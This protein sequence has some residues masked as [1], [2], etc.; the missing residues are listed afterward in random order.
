MDK[1]VIFHRFKSFAVNEC[2]GSSNLYE[3]LSERTAE[4]EGLLELCTNSQGGQPI[5]N[6]FFGAVHFLLLKGTSHHLKNFYG[7]ITDTPENPNQCFPYLKDF[8]KK[9]SDE[10]ITVMQRKLV[11][12]NEVRRCS[13]LYPSFCFAYEKVQ[14]PLALIEIGTSAGLQLLW[15]KYSYTYK[16]D[17]VYGNND[18]IVQ[19]NGEVEGRGFPLLRKNSP[20]VASRTGIDLHVSDLNDPDDFLW[21]KAL[22]WPEHNDRRELFERAANYATRNHLNLIEGDGVA[23][24]PEIIKEIPK[25]SAIIV[26][27]THVA[28]QF[29]N[30][31]KLMLLEEI[32]N[33]GKERDTFHLY[34]NMWDGELHLDY[35]LDGNE[36]NFIVGETDSHGRWFT[37]N[38]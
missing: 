13:Y 6:L 29:S 24:L 15:D 33:M 35:Y 10:I 34:N 36:H 32:R 3:I 19:I 28:N 18:S 25:D 23:L 8:C 22:I 9:Y 1:S 16:T 26:F 30:Q 20:P 12:T 17:D 2:R 5:P 27:H 31:D 4:D 38:L 7:S 11:Q 14:K 21:L 37:W